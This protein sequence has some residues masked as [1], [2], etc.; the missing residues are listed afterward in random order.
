MFKSLLLLFP[1]LISCSH[2]KHQHHHEKMNEKFLDPQCNAEQWDEDF[3]K[4]DRDVVNN[5]ELILKHLPV[6]KGDVIAD[7]GAGTGMFEK[8]LSELT[9]PKGKVFAVEIAPSFVTYMKERFHKIPNIEV[10]LSN[11]NTTTLKDNSQNVVIVI[12]T[13]HHFDKPEVMLK[14]FVRILKKDGHLV[15]VD[16]SLTLDSRDWVKQHLKKSKTE[17]IKEISSHGFHFLREEPIPFK[18]SFQLTFKKK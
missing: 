9:G 6:K 12:D 4:N 15:I 10:I 3:Q 5:K 11:E 2:H 17:Y 7:V 8:R 16:F 18:E 14:D 13:Y 1:L